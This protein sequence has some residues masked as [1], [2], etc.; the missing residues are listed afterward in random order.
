MNEEFTYIYNFYVKST[1]ALNSIKHV[2][3]WNNS[4][5]KPQLR[6]SLIKSDLESLKS[7]NIIKDKR[8]WKRNCFRLKD[9]KADDNQVQWLWIGS[10]SRKKKYL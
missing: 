3:V 9:Y 1:N 7:V 2:H 4:C 6:D 5:F 8:I 10:W